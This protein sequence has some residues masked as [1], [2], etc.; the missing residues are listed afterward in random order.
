MAKFVY[1]NC[2]HGSTKVSPFFANYGFH[3]CFSISISETSVNPSVESVPTPY[4]M[5][6]VTSSSSFVPLANSI[7]LML[8]DIA[9]SHRPSP[10]VTWFCCYVTT[11][12]P[13]TLQLR[14]GYSIIITSF[15]YQLEHVAPEYYKI[16]TMILFPATLG[17]RK[18]WSCYLWSFGGPNLG[19]LSKKLSR[20]VTSLSAPKQLNVVH[21]AFSIHFQFLVDLG[22]LSP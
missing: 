6:I 12:Q 11:S 3:P 22:P 9:W 17:S 7:K 5:S 10:S 15:M 18:H 20:H 4:K 2:I 19:N 13:V 14:M 16:T 1:N 8:T 21:T